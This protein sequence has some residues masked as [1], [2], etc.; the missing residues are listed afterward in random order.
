MRQTKL[1][2]MFGAII[3]P[4]YPAAE[5]FVCVDTVLQVLDKQICQHSHFVRTHNVHK[6]NKASAKH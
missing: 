6:G 3:C 1:R 5:E 4:E 2:N